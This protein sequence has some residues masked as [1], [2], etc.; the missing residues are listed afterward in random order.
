[1][2]T[3]NQKLKL[4]PRGE[5]QLKYITFKLSDDRTQI[6]VDK[7][8]TSTDYDRFL[9]DLPESECRWAAYDFE[10][11]LGEGKR[12]KIVFISWYVPNFLQNSELE[13]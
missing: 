13:D 11:E 3:F 5:P 10:Y 8:S 1:M 2:N 6:V 4:K 7:A 9:E 12:N